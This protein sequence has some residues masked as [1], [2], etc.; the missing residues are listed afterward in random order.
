MQV[1]MTMEEYEE[2]KNQDEVR[3]T[4]E[5]KT[6]YLKNKYKIELIKLQMENDKLR[7]ELDEYRRLG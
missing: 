3:N 4:Y 1:T 7:S 2:L 6:E 5:S